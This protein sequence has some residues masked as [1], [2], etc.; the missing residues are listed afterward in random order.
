MGNMRW[1]NSVALP[2]C[3][4]QRSIN[5]KHGVGRK[6]KR[7]PRGFP[8]ELLQRKTWCWWKSEAVAFVPGFLPL[9]Y[10]KK[11]GNNSN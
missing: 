9:H 3:I 6:A 10:F 8:K 1:W 7:V 11:S 5:G 2:R 4:F